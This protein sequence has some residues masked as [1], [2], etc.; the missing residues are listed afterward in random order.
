MFFLSYLYK[1][2][3]NV[4]IIYFLDLFRTIIYMGLKGSATVR[5]ILI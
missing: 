3:I 5:I 2:N 1:Q 4:V